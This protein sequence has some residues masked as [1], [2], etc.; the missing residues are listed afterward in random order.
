MANETRNEFVVLVAKILVQWG[1]HKKFPQTSNLPIG[2]ATE[3][4]AR[5]VIKQYPSHVDIAIDIIK[6][7]PGGMLKYGGPAG[8]M[9]Y[10]RDLEELKMRQEK[11]AQNLAER[12]NNDY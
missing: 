4:I 12:I 5:W 2:D 10:R 7:L 8:P 9:R 6:G 3:A 11:E 1:F